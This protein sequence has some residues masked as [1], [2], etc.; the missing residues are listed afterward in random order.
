MGSLVDKSSLRRYAVW[1]LCLLT[2]H[3]GEGLWT[4]KCPNFIEETY[5]LLAHLAKILSF[6]HIINIKIEEPWQLQQTIKCPDDDINRNNS[7]D[8]DHLPLGEGQ[9]LLARGVVRGD[10]RGKLQL[11][12]RLILVQKPFHIFIDNNM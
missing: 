2:K 8:D 7:L 9:L 11:L 5:C 3:P 1:R 10:H 4:S 12:P 6:Y